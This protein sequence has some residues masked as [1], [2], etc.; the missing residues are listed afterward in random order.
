MPDNIDLVL[1][2]VGKVGGIEEFIEVILFEIWIN[3]R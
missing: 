3:G 1:L 2:T